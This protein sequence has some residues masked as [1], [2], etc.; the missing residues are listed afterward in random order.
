MNKPGAVELLCR[1][2]DDCKVHFHAHMHARFTQD[3]QRPLSAEEQAALRAAIERHGRHNWEA[4]AADVGLRWPAWRL[5]QCCHAAER[6]AAG[7]DGAEA[8]DAGLDAKL[9]K[10]AVD[11]TGMS[12]KRRRVSWL[13]RACAG[14]VQRRALHGHWCA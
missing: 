14:C 5:L 12:N 10:A 4:V 13:V 1:A 9:I 2:A 7:S 6:E 11:L 8:W 3:F